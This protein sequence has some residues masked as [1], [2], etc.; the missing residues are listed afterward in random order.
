M[1]KFTEQNKVYAYVS[2]A[3]IG[4]LTL[5]L[6]PSLVAAMPLTAKNQLERAWRFA[7]DIGSYKYSSTVIQTDHPI[8]DLRNAGRSSTAGDNPDTKRVSAQGT[9]DLPNK[10]M[11]MKLWTVGIDQDGIEIKIENGKAYGRMNA[12][13]GW[14]EMSDPS[15]LF[16]PGGDPLGFLLAAENIQELGIRSQELEASD[17]TLD[18][19]I[20]NPQALNP[21]LSKRYAFDINGAKYAEYVRQQLE[22]S[23]R[24][25]GELPPNITLGV[26]A[27]YVDMT[28]HGEVWLDEDGLPVRQV[29][30][31][32]FP[33]SAARFTGPRTTS[34]PVFPTGTPRPSTTNFSGPSPA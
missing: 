33:R 17:L 7:S 2:L 12:E 28:G 18:D 31:M 15:Q 25:Q 11:S 22:A 6:W 14:V 30:H 20:T 13:G 27:H 9:V 1:K 24:E 19:V 5:I 29:V 10:T 16:A 3:L 23:M 34:P 8:A 21:N 32:K 26:L 4:L